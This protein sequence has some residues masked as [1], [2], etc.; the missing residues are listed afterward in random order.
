MFE[1]DKSIRTII[2]RN[3]NLDL[4]V[5]LE[6]FEVDWIA[7]IIWSAPCGTSKSRKL[8]LWLEKLLACYKICTDG[9]ILCALSSGRTKNN[10]CA[11][12]CEYSHELAKKT[13]FNAKFRKYASR[14]LYLVLMHHLNVFWGCKKI[15]RRMLALFGVNN[16][17]FSGNDLHTTNC[18]C[19]LDKITRIRLVRD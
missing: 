15:F 19:K 10:F 11:S 18:T 6:I 7:N 2:D 1:C 16:R 12:N 3:K 9:A 13:H 4:V 17:L 14:Q 8:N 5:P